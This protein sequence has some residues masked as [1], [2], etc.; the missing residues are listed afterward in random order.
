MLN[1]IIIYIIPSDLTASILIGV[2]L[3]IIFGLAIIEDPRL[4]IREIKL[5]LSCSMKSGQISLHT[6]EVSM[7]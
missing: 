5:S 4:E 2:T 6:A 1:D 7:E 3:A